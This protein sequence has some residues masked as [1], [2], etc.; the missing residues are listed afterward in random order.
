MDI[1]LRFKIDK[2]KIE[3]WNSGEK[4]QEKNINRDKRARVAKE[5]ALIN[6][7]S[8]FCIDGAQLS[9]DLGFV[10]FGNA[11][12]LVSFYVFSQKE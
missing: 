4:G 10:A 12:G 5:E 8:I 6:P 2:D 7:C 1:K 3:I 9:N 11:A